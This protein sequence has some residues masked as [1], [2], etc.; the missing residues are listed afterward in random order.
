MR[1]T[2]TQRRRD[3]GRRRHTEADWQSIRKDAEHTRTGY[4]PMATEI[5]YSFLLPK[6][7]RSRCCK[8]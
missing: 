6:N 3:R 4:V 5:G 2:E 1:Q 7:K 8:V